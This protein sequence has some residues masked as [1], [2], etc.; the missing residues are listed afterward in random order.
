MN[1][2]NGKPPED[3][4]KATLAIVLALLS[5]M[6]G[7]AGIVWLLVLIKAGLEAL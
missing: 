1:G 7:V 3:S 4:A 5:V 6:L 2:S